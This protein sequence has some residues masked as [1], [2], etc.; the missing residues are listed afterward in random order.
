MKYTVVKDEEKI[1]DNC[2]Y[3][4][5]PFERLDENRKAVFKIG[6]TTNI[7]KRIENYHSEFS[8]GVYL[9]A[10]L[11]YDTKNRKTLGE[12]ERFIFK[13]IVEN[14]GIQ[15]KATTRKN[16]TEWFY[17]NIPTIH[18]AFREAQTKFGGENELNNLYHMNKKADTNEKKKPNYIGEI[19]YHLN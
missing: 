17:T 6:L 19:I 3:C 18:K 5:L 16:G 13:K 9:V 4:I 14:G 8:L 12:A 7:G 1:K 10:F 11:Q 15:I 2:I